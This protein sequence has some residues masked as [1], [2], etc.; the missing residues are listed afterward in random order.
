MFRFFGIAILTLAM[1]YLAT[2]VQLPVSSQS[3]DASEVAAPVW[4]KTN[5]GWER[6]ELWNQKITQ[7]ESKLPTPVIHPIPATIMIY[8]LAMLAL[9]SVP[10]LASRKRPFL[11]EQTMS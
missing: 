2:S 10:T 5:R 3:S 7:T 9:S 1:G 4:R 6:A 8:A 11:S